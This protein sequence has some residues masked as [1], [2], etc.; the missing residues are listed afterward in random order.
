MPKTVYIAGPITGVPNYW[1][2]FEKVEDT[3]T[4]LGYNAISPSRLPQ[5]LTKAQ[6]M[7][8]CLGMIDSADAVVFLSTWEK[9]EGARLEREYCQYTEK[10]CTV[11]RTATHGDPL[12]DEIARAWLKHDLE[13]VLK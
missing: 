6:Y 1:V 13:E 8:I 11:V 5:G 12:P 4:G 10:P 9:S 2:A 7:R 3:L